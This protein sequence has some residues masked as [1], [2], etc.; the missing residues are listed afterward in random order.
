MMAVLPEDDHGSCIRT[1]LQRG[2]NRGKCWQ[3]GCEDEEGREA[4]Q[5]SAF[6]GNLAQCTCAPPARPPD[7]QPGEGGQAEDQN[8]TSRSPV[9]CRTTTRSALSWSR[10]R[11]SVMAVT[12]TDRNAKSF[13]GRCA[14]SKAVLQ[15]M[16]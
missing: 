2:A 13:F 3:A 5:P 16:Q 9:R 10:R 4:E 15:A 12:R 7:E 8:R 14:S 6:Q 1:A 11:A